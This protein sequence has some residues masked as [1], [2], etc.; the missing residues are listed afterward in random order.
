MLGFILKF[1]AQEKYAKSIID[2]TYS[3]YAS[4]TKHNRAG[5]G[6]LVKSKLNEPM[7]SPLGHH[8]PTADSIKIKWYQDSIYKTVYNQ[9]SI[10]S[11]TLMRG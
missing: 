2:F 6:G 9:T 4:V 8:E 11:V 7:G 1:I 3:L 10:Q 5:Q